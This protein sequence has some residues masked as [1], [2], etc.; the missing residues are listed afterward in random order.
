MPVYNSKIESILSLLQTASRED[1]VWM[2]GYLSATLG[3]AGGPSASLGPA[4]P[5]VPKLSRFTLAYGTETGNSKKLATTLAKKAK[6]RGFQ[7]KLVAVDQFRL[8]D[9]PKETHFFFIVSTQGDGEPPA[10]ALSF[11][12]AIQQADLDLKA[13]NFAVLALGDTGYPLFCQAGI[14]ADHHLAARGAHRLLPLVKCDTVYEAE[15]EQWLNDLLAA[16]EGSAGPLITDISQPQAIPAIAPAGPGKAHFQGEVLTNINLNDTPS[17][18]ETSHIEIRCDSPIDYAPGDAAGFIPHNPAPLVERVLT[19]LGLNGTEE[20]AFRGQS[21]PLR[22]ILTQKTNLS[23]LPDRVI[24]KYAA[25][26]SRVIEVPRQNLDELLTAFPPGGLDPSALL[27]ILEPIVPRLYSISSS[28]AAHPG[29]LHLTVAR[30]TFKNADGSVGGGLCST[31][32]C[33][34]PVESQVEFHIHRNQAFKLPAPETD[35][36][37]VGPGTGIAPFRSFLFER[38]AQGASGRNWLFFGD[39]HFVTDFLYQT[40]LQDFLKT[41]VLHRLD[42]AFSRDQAEKIYVQH[43]LLEHAAEVFAWLQNGAVF[44]VCGARTPMSTDVENTLL[45]IIGTQGNLDP[46]AARS[47]LDELSD[48]GR[49]LKDVY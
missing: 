6:E 42:T 37:M 44:Y 16:L 22:E 29:E 23:W 20:V 24:K 32:L 17:A 28:P 35:I 41:G 47:Y 30:S 15:S 45:R 40:E 46:E 7:V 36:I 33:Q 10:A 9:L 34:L 5:G 48:N 21:G 39:Q 2:H 26:T 11:F 1:L 3:V 19:A 13:M 18:K 49:Y 4:V 8:K 31:F 14:D 43:R 12:E 27:E 38:D 25:L